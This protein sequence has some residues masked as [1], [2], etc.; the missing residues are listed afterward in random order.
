MSNILFDSAISLDGYFAGDNRSP[1]NPMGGISGKIH[2]WM[3]HQKAFW[4]H[5]GMEGGNE[6]GAEGR[7]IRETIARTGAYIMGKRMFE[8][9]EVSW[10]NNL[11]KADVYVLTHEKRE[12]W[13][14]E[15][16]TRFF[17]INDGIE[18]ALEKA[19]QSAKGKDIRIQGGAHTIQQFLNAGLV[20]EFFI[21]V[22]PVFLGSGIRLF[23]GINPNLYEL[24]IAEVIPSEFT[25]HIRYKL[26][27]K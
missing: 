15:G 3:F 22:A 24:K 14:Q 7:F 16:S 17:F 11:Y 25:T 2:S 4:E 23:E 20:D 10:P 1:Q 21:H 19:R 9:G 27:R 5:L 26:N 6:D 8:E 12:P 13:V 18:S